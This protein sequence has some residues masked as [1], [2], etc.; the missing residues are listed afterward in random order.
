MGY[1]RDLF[2]SSELTARK[3]RD[4]G[5]SGLKDCVSRLRIQGLGF[6]AGGLGFRICFRGFG[7]N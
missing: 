6:R 2:S 3:P 5:L 7:W 4:S 1:H